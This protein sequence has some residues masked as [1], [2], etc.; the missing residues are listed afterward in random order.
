MTSKVITLLNEKGGVGKTTLSVHIAAGLA[1]RG[2]RVL[3]LDTDAQAHSTFQLGVKEFGGLY[4]LLAQESEW[5]DVLRVADPAA[6]AGEHVTSGA[7]M[8]LPSN[9]ET[10]VI[11]MVVDD[12]T[13]LR[14][15]LEEMSQY[16]D[17]VVIDTSPTPSLL[18]SMIYLASD[19]M[20]YPSECEALAL[21]GLAK[22]VYHMKKL[23]KTRQAAGLDSVKL[24]GVQPTKYDP[25]T[26]AHRY[27]LNLIGKHFG[28]QLAWDAIPVRTVWRDAAF[29]KRTLFA[30][31]PDHIG[32][33]EAWG[34]VDRVMEGISA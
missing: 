7:L 17:V 32:A 18:H 30:Y 26:N 29:A 2:A 23:Q 5:K 4:R 20:V 33:V 10:R 12:V 6:W 13:L 28:Q 1:I 24:L 8:V 11:P 16:A 19:Y 22:S 25:R 14:E 31:Q 27:A 21:D 15:R 34:L 9:V 3:L